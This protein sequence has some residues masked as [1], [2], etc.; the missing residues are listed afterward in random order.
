MLVLF[1]NGIGD[2]FQNVMQCDESLLFQF[3]FWDEMEEF[4]AKRRIRDVSV[5]DVL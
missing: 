4:L 2:A 5:R 3:E 1:G